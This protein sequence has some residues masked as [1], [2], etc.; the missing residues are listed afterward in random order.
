M[1]IVLGSNK[2]LFKRN[3]WELYQYCSVIIFGTGGRI[4]EKIDKG[5]YVG[6]LAFG[7][8]KR[9]VFN[10]IGGYDEELIRNQ[11][12][13]FNMRLIQ[14]KGT[15]WMDPNIQS[16]YYPRSTYEIFYAIFTVWLF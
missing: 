16:T 4:S 8:Y 3:I 7:A 2:K 15:I 1:Q 12:D 14:N 9:Y 10:E 11:D 13:E 5:K 6:T